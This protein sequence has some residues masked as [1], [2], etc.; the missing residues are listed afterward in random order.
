M[1][2]YSDCW[3]QSSDGLRLHYR[4]YPGGAATKGE[5]PPLVCLPGLTRNARDFEN[6]AERLA[7]EWRVLC[8]ELRGRGASEYAQDW[9]TYNLLQYVSDINA[10]L[11]QAGIT[12]FV[13]VGTSLGGL[14]TLVMAMMDAGT[15][16]NRIA[17]VLLNDIGPVLE[18]TGLDRIRQY[19]GQAQQFSSW[20]QAAQALA[21]SQAAVCPDYRPT[22]WLALAHRLM[23]TDG[24]GAIVFD[25]DMQIARA[26][27]P[28]AAEPAAA[29]E[30]DLWPGIDSLAHCPVLLVRGG[31]SELLSAETFAQMCQRLPHA[32]AVTLPRIG[33]VPT[34]DEP[35]VAA[36]I[37]RWL[38]WV[39]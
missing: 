16:T 19:V 17:G 11:D 28:E 9:A 36:A 13:A 29:P 25:Y 12:R 35:E 3:W 6:L 20:T 4:D 39:A 14:M 26:F 8:P 1:S 5:R 37:A 2:A 27:P 23:T 33:H 15:A 7:G 30:I 34:L 10:L 31:L 32:E 21:E 18:A 22:D 24:S 38:T